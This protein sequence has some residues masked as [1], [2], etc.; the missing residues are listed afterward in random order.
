MAERAPNPPPPGARKIRLVDAPG[1]ATGKRRHDEWWP[2]PDSADAP[3]FDWAG[4]SPPAAHDFQLR[5]QAIRVRRAEVQLLREEET[6]Y[7]ERAE[8]EL[9]EIARERKLRTDSRARA[10]A[11]LHGVV[12]LARSIVLLIFS[13]W[14]LLL[15]CLALSGSRLTTD[16]GPAAL[17]HLLSN[18]VGHI[19]IPPGG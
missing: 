2:D 1:H 17:A 13:T 5:L 16:L 11:L 19:E 7:A 3:I 8:N 6:L 4:R 9:N 12:L 15:A 14:A 18:A 10:V